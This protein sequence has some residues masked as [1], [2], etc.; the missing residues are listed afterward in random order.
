MSTELIKPIRPIFGQKQGLAKRLVEAK[1]NEETFDPMSRPNR[2]GIVMDDSGSM[3]QQGMEKAHEAIDLFIKNCSPNDTCIAIYPL[4][5]D[6]K[7]LSNNFLQVAMYSA[8]IWATGGTPLYTKL[9]EVLKSQPIT[10]AVAFSDGSPTDNYGCENSEERRDV[11]TIRLYQEANV[12]VDT[13][14]IGYGDSKVMQELA[15]KTGGIYLH[16]TDPS[17]LA[18]SLK[19]LAP[20][21]RAMLTDGGFKYKV[22]RGEA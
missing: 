21:Y 14:F 18:K 15:E 12:P 22:E 9:Q 11:Q 4:N 3:G 19:Y 6:G 8:G 5:A 17:V 1:A 13:I 20:K 2:I 7:P 10:R 16:F